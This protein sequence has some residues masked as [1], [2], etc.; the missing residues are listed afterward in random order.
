[1]PIDFYYA[2]ASSPAGLVS[3]V[4]EAIDL[5]LNHKKINFKEGDLLKPAFLKVNNY[6]LLLR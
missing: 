4:A 2:E 3:M 1:M 5:E 6:G